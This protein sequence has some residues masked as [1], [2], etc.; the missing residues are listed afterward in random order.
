MKNYDV[1]YYH[2]ALCSEI[3]ALKFYSGLAQELGGLLGKPL[4]YL[5]LGVTVAKLGWDNRSLFISHV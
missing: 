5:G 4:L 2:F 3:G 1:D